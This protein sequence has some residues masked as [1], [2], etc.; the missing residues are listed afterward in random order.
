MLEDYERKR[1]GATPEPRSGA[2]A[3][4]EGPLRFMIHCHHASHEHYDLRLELG[5]AL[6]SWALP[7]RPSYDLTIKR[8]AAHVEDHPIPYGDF[9]GTIPKG[10][11]GGGETV[12]W[13]EGFYSPDEGGKY[14]WNN[15]AEA[16][17]RLTQELADGKLSITFRGSKMLGSWA[18]V[19]TKDGWLFLKHQ[20]GFSG[21]ARDEKLDDRSVRTGRIPPD[22]AESKPA[23]DFDLSSLTGAEAGAL[24]PGLSP[25]LPQEAKEAFDDSAWHFQVK[26]DGIRILVYGQDGVVKM[27]TR[28]GKQVGER[29]PGLCYQLSKLP[30]RTWMLDGELVRVTPDGKPSFTSLMERFMTQGTA[31][32]VEYGMPIEFCAFDVLHLDGYD[33][34]SCSLEDRL[35]VLNALHFKAPDFKVLDSFPAAGKTLFNFAIQMGFEGIMAKKLTSKYRAGQRDG[36]WLKVKN[37]QSGEF[38]V[39]G[40]SDGE[41]GRSS[42]FGSLL[43]G[44]L[45]PDGSLKYVGSV[46]SGFNEQMLGALSP[47]LK[48][49]AQ[50]ES[51]FANPVDDKVLSELHYIQPLIWAEIKYQEIGS[52][53]HLRFPVFLR[54][55]PDLEPPSSSPGETLVVTSPS[56]PAEEGPRGEGAL[57]Q[58]EAIKSD[59]SS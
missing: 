8:F 1:L 57:A 13:D 9:E 58:L 55:R 11:Y 35:K 33:L 25:M 30:F 24:N 52:G 7:K 51:P 56:P 28:N 45:E 23:F 49:L 42:T 27:K 46:G 5:G 39:G 26:L 17:A 22:L 41:G 48:Q 16:E 37:L 18:L 10:N 6:K 2:T 32:W 34:T 40:W 36:A 14:S 59:G 50:K 31:P 15:R 47:V 44:Q 4:F 38:V 43:L 20:D 12:I 19:K 3:G 21:A 53:G 54:L 29:F